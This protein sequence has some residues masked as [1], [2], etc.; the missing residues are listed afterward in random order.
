M[1][2]LQ[3]GSDRSKRGIL[4]PDTPA[5]KRQAAYGEK[6]GHLD[7]VGF[8]LRDDGR[9][10]YEISEHTH[11]YP[12]NSFS[13][14]FYG[15]D[16]IRIIR[17]LPKPD[18]ISVQDP[19]EAGLLGLL[20]S[21]W[22]QVPLHVQVHTD[23]FSSGY[24]LHSALNHVRAIVARI[25]LAH[26]NRIRSV[27][28][29]IQ[30]SIKAQTHAKAAISVL[31]IFVDIEK[32]KNATRI[33]ELEARFA[34]FTTKLLVVS[35]LEPEKN[36]AL[37]ID[38][39]AQSAPPEACLIIVATGS[40]QKS[41]EALVRE[42]NISD[43]IFFEGEHQAIDYYPLASLVLVTSYYEGYGLVIIEALA[44][45]KPVLSTDVGIASEMGAIIADQK[46][47]PAALSA[48]FEGGPR[49]MTLKEYPYKNF[50]DYVQK[51]CEDVALSIKV[52]VRV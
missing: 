14:L 46:D 52:K 38:S 1:R 51:Y 16:T 13:K 47:F 19:F 10:P 5:A 8:S 18:V 35:R 21:W 49:A 31:P 15:L 33:P 28:H 7:I 12:T 2:V 41:L 17:S 34:K 36:V 42:K 4:Y 37:A 11:V 50:D 22:M 44:A 48:W 3:I 26:A 23:I 29:R 20:I 45:D 24:L 40:Q 6:F 25:V 9:K 39:F 32:F 27:S 30:K 43:R